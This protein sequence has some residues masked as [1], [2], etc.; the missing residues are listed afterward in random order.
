MYSQYNNYMPQTRNGINWVQGVEGA[1]AYQLM[2]NTNTVLMDS[3]NDNIF[4]IKVCDSVGMC[5]LRTFKYEEIT[6]FG[7]QTENNVD[8]SQYVTRDELS[9]ILEEL[10][11]GKQTVSTTKHT[12]PS[13]TA[14]E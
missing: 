12:K 13:T 9:S 11:Y 3:E 4:Y 2:P 14:E 6:N 5:S 10:K 1:K 8:L 7:K